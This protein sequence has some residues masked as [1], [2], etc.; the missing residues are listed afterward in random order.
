[1]ADEDLI[2]NIQSQL[3]SLQKQVKELEIENAKLKSQVSGCQCQSTLETANVID[4][5]QD[6]ESIPTAPCKQLQKGKGSMIRKGSNGDVAEQTKESAVGQVICLYLRPN[7]KEITENDASFAE[8]E[9]DYVK[10]IGRWSTIIFSWRDN[11][12]I[13]AMEIA[14]KKFLGEHDFRNCCKIDALNVHNYK[15]CV[16]SFEIT[17]VDRFKDKELWAVNI[18]GSV[19]LWHQ[20]VCEHLENECH[21]LVLQAG[22]FQ[23]ALTR[24]SST[25][26]GHQLKLRE[27]KLLMFLSWK[28]RLSLSFN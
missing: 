20:A 25:R 7:C 16:I 14:G 10:N 15:Q 3:C 2:A 6:D 13:S 4:R 17:R 26:D 19:F 11:L 22:I 23:E 28:E 1:M 12:N 27:E 18:K 9:I 24:A 21:S 8:G 5:V